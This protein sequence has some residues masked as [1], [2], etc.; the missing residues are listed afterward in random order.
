MY[1][2]DSNKVNEYLSTMT[3]LSDELQTIIAS[4][5][6]FEEKLVWEGES[7]ELN[8]EN[9][10]KIMSYEEELCSIID[11]FIL[12]YEKGLNGFGMTTE[13]LQKEFES[14]K[15]KNNIIDKEVSV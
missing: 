8:K 10:L 5:K 12:I 11:I 4:M 3:N 1:Q 14:I 7:G 13:E 6:N 2:I 9:Y 15:M